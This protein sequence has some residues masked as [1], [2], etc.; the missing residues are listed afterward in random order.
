VGDYVYP[1]SIEGEIVRFGVVW[2]EDCTLARLTFDGEE[3]DDVVILG[4]VLDGLEAVPDDQGDARED[5]IP[6]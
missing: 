5:E 2:N 6:Y 3:V 1:D 4:R